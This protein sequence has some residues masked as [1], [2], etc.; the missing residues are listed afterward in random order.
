MNNYI[1]NISDLIYLFIDGETNK[2]EQQTL[3]KE[4]ANNDECNLNFR[5]Q[6]L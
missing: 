2:I 1:E 3:F 4:L 6:C 5:K